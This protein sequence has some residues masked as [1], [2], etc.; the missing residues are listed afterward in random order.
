M[1]FPDSE[2][3]LY[4]KNP[5]QEVISQFR[6]PTILRIREGQLAAF[7]D[8]IGKDYPIYSEQEPSFAVPPELPKELATIVEQM[9]VPPG[10]VTHR[11][12]TKDSR[13]FISL[14]D[15]IMALAETK[16]EKWESFREEITKAEAAL[17][18]VYEP[19][20]YSRVG[21]RYRDLISLHSL[22]LTDVRWQDLIKTHVIAELGDKNVGDAILR[23]QTRAI[24]KI[25]DIASGRIMLSH[26][27]VIPDGSNEKCYFIDADFSVE[28]KEGINE[29]FKILERF[30]RLAGQLFRWAITERLHKAMEPR[31]I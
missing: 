31:A 7:Q 4:D 20:F 27:L 15:D 6:F 12:S 13:R 18:K 22:N 14:R 11:F 8:I 1:L 30:N 2:R 10:L 24:I 16:Y 28:R 29:P 3:V 23:I 26:G 25:P 9:N 17:R 5:L 21:L 19:A